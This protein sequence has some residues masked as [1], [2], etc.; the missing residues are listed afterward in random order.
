MMCADHQVML[1]DMM[2]LPS[3]SPHHINN[4]N[5]NSPNSNNNKLEGGGACQQNGPQ[6]QLPPQGPPQS[7]SGLGP[8]V[9]PP[10]LHQYHQEAAQSAATS[11]GC[12]S[13]TDP[14]HGLKNS[15][16]DTHHQTGR[17]RAVNDVTFKT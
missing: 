7:H 3:M 1:A 2:L 14:G 4:N 8:P 10:G 11:T 13:N 6:H 16:G 17:T 15:A 5:N 9:G 12:P